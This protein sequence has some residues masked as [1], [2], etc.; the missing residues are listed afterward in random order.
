LREASWNFQALGHNVAV[1]ARIS[2]Y[3]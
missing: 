2:R 1:L 3:I